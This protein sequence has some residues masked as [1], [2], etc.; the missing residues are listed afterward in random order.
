VL[1]RADSMDGPKE[2]DGWRQKKD[3]ADKKL[4]GKTRS[5]FYKKRHSANKKGVILRHRHIISA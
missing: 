4:D 3:Q 2:D 5:L 1:L